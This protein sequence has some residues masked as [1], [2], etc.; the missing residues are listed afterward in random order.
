MLIGPQLL[1]A[2]ERTSVSRAQATM[3]A[4]FPPTGPPAGAAR[5]SESRNAATCRCISRANGPSWSSWTTP[6]VQMCST[7]PCAAISSIQRRSHARPS[8]ALANPAGVASM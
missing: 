7:A 3:R 6:W 8:S 4:A 1:T 2:D 5:D